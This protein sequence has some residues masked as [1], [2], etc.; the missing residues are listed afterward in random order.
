[1]KARFASLDV[2]KNGLINDSDVALLAKNLAGFRKEGK[3]AE[4]RYFDT[5]KSVW[6]YGIG[7][8]KGVN[9]EEYIRAMKEFVKLP[10]A[11]ER[12]NAYSS[13]LFD[14]MDANQ[15]GVISLEECLEFNR[16]AAYWSD[17]MI[18]QQFQLTD[19]NGDGVIQRSEME[20]TVAKYVLSA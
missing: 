11:R 12:L 9:E 1:M 19:T 5:L 8:D 16:A 17:E 18:K 20:E 15:D 10:D 6:S 7:D 3:D 4:K 13:M 2:D 14:I